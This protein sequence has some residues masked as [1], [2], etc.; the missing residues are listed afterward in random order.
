LEPSPASLVRSRNQRLSS[1]AVACFDDWKSSP[2][3]PSRVV[4]PMTL[5]A[6]VED[7]DDDITLLKSRF[8]PGGPKLP[9][10][11]REPDVVKPIVESL[12]ENVT[13]DTFQQVDFLAKN[14]PLWEAAQKFIPSF[15]P[16]DCGM[17]AEDVLL[18][19]SLALSAA[20][21]E[22][23]GFQPHELAYDPDENSDVELLP[24]L[25]L[26]AIFD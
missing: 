22:A 9:V 10:Q 20:R 15:T 23:D 18:A 14:E 16:S 8:D 13:H 17:T 21:L 7:H 26:Q 6:L 11:L 2:T 3:E 4:H 1:S 25:E 5:L 19:Q 12:S 24:D